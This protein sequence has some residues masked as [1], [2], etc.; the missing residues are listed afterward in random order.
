MMMLGF[1]AQSLV[2]CIVGISLG[3]RDSNLKVWK[4]MFGIRASALNISSSN[5]I[6]SSSAP[7]TGHK[8]TL[9]HASKK[10]S[11]SNS[12]S[13]RITLPAALS[14]KTSYANKSNPRLPVPVA[15]STVSSV[16]VVD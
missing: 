16:A 6:A 5:K 2:S 4:Q 15:E 8:H 7:G 3:F 13:S 1:L 11:Y 9:S 10:G 12:S 14:R